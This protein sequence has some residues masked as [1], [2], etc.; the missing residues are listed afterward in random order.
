MALEDRRSEDSHTSTSSNFFKTE[1]VQEPASKP[2]AVYRHYAGLRSNDLPFVLFLLLLVH[3]WDPTTK[4]KHRKTKL[5][6][7]TV[8][9][10]NTWENTK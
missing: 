1:R 9:S 6:S 7:S 3:L 10:L 4:K 2:G 8:V 5:A